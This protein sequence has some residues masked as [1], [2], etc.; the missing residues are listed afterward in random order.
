MCGYLRRHTDNQTMR[1]YYEAI[2]IPLD[3]PQNV[4]CEPEAEHFYPAFGKNPSRQITGMVIRGENG[5][6]TPVAATWWYD[7]SELNGKLIVGD[8]TTFNARNLSSSYWKGGIRHFRGI[9]VASG[10]GEGKNVD[11][12]NVHYLMRSKQPILLGTIYRRFP[13]GAYSCAVITRDSQPG[14]DRYHDKAFPLMLPNDPHFLR[15]WLADV[16]ESES[17]VAELLAFPKVFNDLEVVAVKTLKG[18]VPI[19]EVEYLNASAH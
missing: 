15:L 10:I 12:K 19:G 3:W 11:G 7:C 5:N 8:R 2:Q 17:I 14:F 16:P 9:A 13:S 6:P 4:G 1:E 18:G